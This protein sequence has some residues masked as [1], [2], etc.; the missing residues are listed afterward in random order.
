[1]PKSVEDWI[2][3]G[4]ADTTPVTTSTPATEAAD[5]SVDSTTQVARDEQGRFVSTSSSTAS[6]TDT[7][8]VTAAPSGTAEVITPAAAAS[9]P[10]ISE[11]PA[12]VEEFLEV[13][14]GDKPYQI[15]K[16]L[17]L[18]WKRG[19]ESGF[20]PITEVLKSPF[21][22]KDYRAKTAVTAEE[23]RQNAIER[24]RNTAEKE[25]IAAEREQIRAAM[26]DPEKLNAYNEHFEQMQKNPVYRANVELALKQRVTEAELNVR[27]DEERES[28]NREAAQNL[29]TTIVETAKE[30]PGVDPDRVRQIYAKGL[31]SGDIKE[32]TE[33]SIH[34]VY[35]QEADYTKQVVG[36]LQGRLAELEAQIAKLTAPTAIAA[37]NA[38]TDK[39]LAQLKAAPVIVATG[40][41][42]AVGTSNPPTQFKPFTDKEYPDKQREWAARK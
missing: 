8:P 33:E 7:V 23:K 39:K 14:R 13:M 41:G 16:D 34:Q 25:A 32:I 15:P 4:T 30:Y 35:R 21:F 37:H 42:T 20:S 1:M 22:E 2:Q 18:P 17:M 38:T 28:V 5:T 29:Y 6:A 40:N 31:V 9:P 19:N 11:T 26:L 10:P 24:A 27:L 12:T 36:P 3:D